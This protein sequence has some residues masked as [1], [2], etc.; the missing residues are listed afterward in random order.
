M[1]LRSM[2]CKRSMAL[3]FP[4]IVITLAVATAAN[5][6]K[7][8]AQSTSASSTEDKIPGVPGTVP[9]PGKIF[10]REQKRS[11][12]KSNPKGLAQELPS[13]S[14]EE[15]DASLESDDGSP[16]T[17]SDS[18]LRPDDLGNGLK[19]P[20][21]N[22]VDPKSGQTLNNQENSEQANAKLLPHLELAPAPGIAAYLGQ[23][24]VLRA[25]Q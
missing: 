15:T 5:T 20:S 16:P 17:K 8:F 11:S 21:V 22:Q 7:V 6:S 3:L 2:C 14:D 10:L 24:L 23:S 1:R 12:K 19:L 9:K 18:P 4:S 13:V 25:K